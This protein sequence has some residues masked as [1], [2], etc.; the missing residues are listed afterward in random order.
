MECF[1]CQG[2]NDTKYLFI[3]QRPSI[4]LHYTFL[5]NINVF[6]IFTCFNPHIWVYVLFLKEIGG[7]RGCVGAMA[8]RSHKPVRR[9]SDEGSAEETGEQVPEIGAFLS[10]SRC[11]QRRRCGSS[12]AACDCLSSPGT[13]SYH[14]LQDLLHLI[15]LLNSHRELSYILCQQTFKIVFTTLSSSFVE[16]HL[17]TVTLKNAKTSQLFK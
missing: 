10:D 7:G 5:Y 11:H 14:H 17:Q 12:A 13:N 1:H 8:C 6:P 4:F 2:T 3:L 9:G 15:F 16:G